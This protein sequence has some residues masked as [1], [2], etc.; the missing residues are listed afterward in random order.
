MTDYS[1][2]TFTQCQLCG[3]AAS[4]FRLLGKRLDRAQGW[5]PDK[6]AGDTTNIVRCAHCGLI[7]CQPMPIPVQLDQHYDIDPQD[8]W[9]EQVIQT[10]NN[11]I[12]AIQT[13]LEALHSKRALDVGSGMGNDLYALKQL[14]FH[15]IG[16]E[17]SR[18]FAEAS[19]KKFAF[20]DSELLIQRFEDC[21]FPA[22]S[23]D[24]ITFG[25]VLEHLP[26]PGDSLKKAVT[27]LAPGGLIQVQV[28]NARWFTA[29][30]INFIY[31]FTGKGFVCNLSPK[32]AP[33]HL[34]EFTEKAF[35]TFAAAHG[36][37][38]V[39]LQYDICDTMLP[40]WTNGLVKPYMR[41]TNSGME[42]NL[43]LQKKTT[44]TNT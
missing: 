2:H 8:Y 35:R 25:A 9:K 43:L 37:D 21:H 18:S 44:W 29:R 32:H 39:L 20:T 15:V 17:P 7:C 30:L 38:I 19:Q 4:Q 12:Q 42:L 31:R 1:L 27:W 36:L 23:F 40:R 26:F 11:S 3:A 24:F 16:I 5:F 10:E 41:L 34:Y 22:A 14:Q 28:P 13:H 33:Y 6:L